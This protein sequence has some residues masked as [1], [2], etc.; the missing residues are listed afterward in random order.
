MPIIDLVTA[1]SHCRVDFGEDDAL[2]TTFID[3]AEGHLVDIGV[4]LSTTPVPSA[5]EGAIL[6]LVGHFYENREAV[7]PKAMHPVA[8]GVDRLIAPHTGFVT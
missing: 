3:V 7:A 8:I 6:L 1:K 5:I 2:I 4:D